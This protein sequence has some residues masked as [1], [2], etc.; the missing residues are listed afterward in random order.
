M[1]SDADARST[2]SMHVDT[3]DGDYSDTCDYDEYNEGKN[4]EDI[5][6]SIFQF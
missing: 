3:D 5:K 2:G 6:H 1:D 4:S